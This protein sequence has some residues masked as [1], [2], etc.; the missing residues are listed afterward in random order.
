[1]NISITSTCKNKQE[2]RK[3]SKLLLQNKLTAC[4]QLEPIESLYTWK[5]KLIEDKEVKITIK[6]VASLYK[7]VEKTILDNHSYEIP[8][9]IV[10]EISGGFDGYLNWLDGELAS[11]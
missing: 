6:T 3:I 11:K 9:I 7:K 5:G 8:E 2:A 1:M 4:V 10:Q